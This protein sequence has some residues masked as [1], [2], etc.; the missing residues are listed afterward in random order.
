MAASH[1]CR[2]AFS[3]CQMGNEKGGRSESKGGYIAGREGKK[4]GRAAT[5]ECHTYLGKLG[6]LKVWGEGVKRG[7]EVKETEMGGLIPNVNVR[8]LLGEYGRNGVDC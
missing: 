1:N 4:R 5:G 2:Q 8:N 6:I 3:I 7:N